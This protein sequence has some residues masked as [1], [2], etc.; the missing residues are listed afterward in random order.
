MKGSFVFM[1]A[2]RT[3]IAATV[4]LAVP[5]LVLSG[6][7]PPIPMSVQPSMVT[8]ER[9]S[10]AAKKV[11]DWMQFGYDAGH[12]GDNPLEKTITAKNVADL[13]IAWNDSIIQPGGVV[14]D[15]NVAYVDD[16]GQTGAGLYALDAA[17]GKQKW[18]ANVNLN[19][20]WGNFTHAVSAVAGTIVVTPCSNGS[21]TQFLTGL[22]GVKASNGKIVWKSYCTLYNGGGCGGMTNG[23]SPALYNNLIYFQIT[24]G[25]NEQPDTEALDPKSGKVVWDD[26]GVYHCP[27]AG[28][29]NGAPLPVV[30]GVVFAVLG[31]QGYQG[32][33][34]VCGLNAS[35]GSAAWCDDSSPYVED[36]MGGDGKFFETVP[37]N[38]NLALTA[39]DAKTGATSWSISL[40][41]SNGSTM[42]L[43]NGTLFVSEG[44]NG[45]YAFSAT[46]GRKIW[47][48][49]SNGNLTNGTVLTVADGVVYTDGGG[50]NNGNTAVTA[51]NAKNGTLLWTSTATGNGGAPLT[52]VVVN[53]TL[54]AGCYT[55]CAFTVAKK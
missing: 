45:V 39:L 11:A 35:S 13:K 46:N 31:C 3:L 47:S 55:L 48:Y 18:Y 28:L 54:Y 33:T 44:G 6:C 50:G 37:G 20:G 7:A 36:A 30:G 4:A 2:I 51:F 14:V 24:E 41:G 12:S 42:A 10:P 26:P 9:L 40:P 15:K 43:A 29:T 38:S 49:T 8:P 32:V 53:G 21:T 17:T 5:S 19:G 22:C 23:T 25:V 27:D 1:S 52:P 34:E 16:M